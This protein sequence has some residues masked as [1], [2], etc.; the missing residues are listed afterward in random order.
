MSKLSISPKV[1]SVMKRETYVL[2][3]EFYSYGHRLRVVRRPELDF[4]CEACKGCFFMGYSVCPKSQCSSFGREDGINVWFVE[5]S[6]DE[7][8]ED[9]K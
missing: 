8:I 4:P 1:R 7:D 6:S 9:C 5:V 3:H 2:G